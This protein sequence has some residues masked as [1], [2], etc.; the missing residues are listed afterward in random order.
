MKCNKQAGWEGRQ[1]GQAGGRGREEPWAPTM[2]MGR[3]K[4]VKK[5]SSQMGGT[6]IIEWEYKESRNPVGVW[7]T[8]ATGNEPAQRGGGKGR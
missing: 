1:K 5:A 7:K 4:Q 3:H 2:G 8:R 6:I